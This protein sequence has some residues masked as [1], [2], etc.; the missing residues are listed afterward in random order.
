MTRR[1]TVCGSA[2]FGWRDWQRTRVSI[3]PLAVL[4]SAAPD[5]TAP[6]VAVSMPVVMD[7]APASSQVPIMPAAGLLGVGAL[8]PFLALRRRESRTEG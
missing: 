6:F 2:P 8:G 4:A 7:T 1:A 3:S 5:P